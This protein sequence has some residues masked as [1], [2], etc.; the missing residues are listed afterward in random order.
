MCLN[1]VEECNVMMHRKS[2]DRTLQGFDGM[3]VVR[4]T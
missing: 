4:K 1:L 3:V 2:V